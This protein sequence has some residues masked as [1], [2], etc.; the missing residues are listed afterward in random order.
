MQM[1]GPRGRMGSSDCSQAQ[2]GA[3][4]ALQHNKGAKWQACFGGVF[5]LLVGQS[6]SDTG[7]KRHLLLSVSHIIWITIGSI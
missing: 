4:S 1:R 2:K 6:L 3:V 5:R 7:S